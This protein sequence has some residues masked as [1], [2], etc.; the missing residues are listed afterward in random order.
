MF[1]KLKQ[2]K[3][4]WLS[5]AVRKVGYY[6]SATIMPNVSIFIVWGILETVIPFVEGDVQVALIQVNE[7]FIR[8]LFPLLIGYTGGK[9][10]EPSRGGIVGSIA[11][12]GII[13]GSSVSPF[14]GAMVLGPLS[15]YLLRSFDRLFLKKI[16]SGYE[17]L[18]RNLSVGL[19][20]GGLCL[21][22]LF[23]LSSWLEIILLLFNKGLSFLII[24]NLLPLTNVFFEVVKVFFFNNA[25][26]HGLL[27]PL[28]LEQV[29]RMGSTI[30]FLIE[31][32]PGPGLGILFAFLCFGKKELQTSATG[33]LFIHLLGGIHEVYFPFVLLNPYLFL[34]VIAGG[35]AGTSV[36]QLLNVG[37][38]APVSPGSLIMILSNT[39]AK[40]MLGVIFGIFV[41]TA[42]TF[43]CAVIILKKTQKG[44]KSE[45]GSVVMG[46][47]DDI[48]FVCDAGMGSSAM[49]A[50]LLRKQLDL[51][52]LRIPVT[53]CS[54]HQLVDRANCL[55][56]Y[57][58][59]LAEMVDQKAPTANK[60][61]ITHFLDQSTYQMII[62]QL[63][64]ANEMLVTDEKTLKPQLSYDKI[65]FLYRDSVRGAQTIA[66]TLLQ[67]LFKEE[68]IFVPVEKQN[69]SAE[70]NSTNLY[71]VTEE[72]QKKSPVLNVPLLVV[73]HLV[74]TE[75]YKQLIRGEEQHVFITS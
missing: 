72:F 13:V 24:N 23:F 75:K 19:I 35:V 54:I 57:Q 64:L 6:L 11:V 17:M 63:I 68:G 12:T 73:E 59:E 15:G 30:L 29:E 14:V 8:F 4:D 62:N 71:I 21:F 18:V 38:K 48:I 10:I 20:G 44:I 50:S 67:Q 58:E 70:L 41:S 32:N 31:A 33:A 49:G 52:E 34:A 46:K 22:S 25:I 5:L 2:Q 65:I 42:C 47:I 69:L 66:V 9:L 74:M 39:P 28:G 40:M 55:I 7:M 51:A 36:F 53:Y 45:K 16:P 26:N 27:T 3:L 61:T 60:L 43:V 56:I 37:L 1:F